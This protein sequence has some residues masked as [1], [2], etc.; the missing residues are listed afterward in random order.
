MD[1]SVRLALSCDVGDILELGNRVRS[2]LASHGQE[3]ELAP[4]V[5]EKVESAIIQSRVFVCESMGAVVGC[6]FVKPVEVLEQLYPESRQAGLVSKI[7]T[8]GA[9]PLVY[10][11][12]VMVEPTQ[13]GKN[14]GSRLVVNVCDLAR[15]RY[16]SSTV[17]LDCAATNERLRRFYESLGFC[18]L[19][20][21]PEMTWEIAVFAS[22][23]I[24]NARPVRVIT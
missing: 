6:A 17:I 22:R 21:V 3:D 8:A 1:A 14:I 12:S 19:D 5:T 16:S 23:P 4:L 11:H 10:L 13:Q 18:L 24:L 15:Q 20:V 2:V 7:S 9:M